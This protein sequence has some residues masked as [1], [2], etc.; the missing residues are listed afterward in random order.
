MKILSQAIILAS[1]TLFFSSCGSDTTKSDAVETLV[2]EE[3]KNWEE[4]NISA[5]GNTMQEMV[6]SEKN[7]NVK[8]IGNPI[9][10]ANNITAIN[11]NPNVAGLMNS[12]IMRQAIFLF[13]QHN[14]F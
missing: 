9:N 11:I 4:F 12:A 13:L 2:N 7:I 10:I 3:I 5:L 1:F 14:D 6:F 8:E